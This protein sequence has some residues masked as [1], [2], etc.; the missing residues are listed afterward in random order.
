[1]GEAERGLPEIE[2]R[3]RPFPHSMPFM[4]QVGAGSE[5]NLIG[6]IALPRK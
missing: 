2:A 6:I 1:L 5:F 3:N 4:A